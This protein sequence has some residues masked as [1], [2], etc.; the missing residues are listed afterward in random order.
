VAASVRA[1]CKVGSVVALIL[2]GCGQSRSGP[3]PPDAGVSFTVAPLALSTPDASVQRRRRPHRH[4]GIASILFRAARELD[5]GPPKLEALETIERS[6]KADDEGIRSAMK[7][8]RF[9]LVSGIR[10]G[11]L[12]SG[13]IAADDGLID[14]AISAHQATEAAAL[15]ALHALLEPAERASIVSSIRVRQKDI[16]SRATG[17]MKEADGGA[18]DWGRRRLDKL[19]AELAL[20]SD[21]QRQVASILAKAVGPPTG[22][23]MEQRWAERRQRTDLLLTAFAGEQ[24][25]ARKLDLSIL[26]GKAPHEAMDRMVAFFA[27]FLPLLHPDQRDK[28]ASSIDQPFGWGARGRVPGNAPSRRIVD[29]IAFP[30][31]EPVEDDEPAPAQQ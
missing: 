26:P 12:A 8:F 7:A 15:D 18:L 5:L 20:D 11:S 27:K 13:K 2:L 14:K 24:F 22:Q 16:E 1:R 10:P 3:T 23:A 25:E 29:D 19:S 31:A 21:Q 9:D 30:F 28:L 6:L 4:G 17:W